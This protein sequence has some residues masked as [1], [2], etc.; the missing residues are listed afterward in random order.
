MR[1]AA[2]QNGS[3]YWNKDEYVKFAYERADAL[4]HYQG[5]K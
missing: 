4:V 2:D 3:H 5:G 1:V